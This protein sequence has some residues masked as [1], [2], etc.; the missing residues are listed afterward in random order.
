MIQQAE[1]ARIR[2]AHLLREVVEVV[3][4]VAVIFFAIRLS[5]ATY[6]VNGPSM[7]PNFLDSQLMAINRLSYV[8]G[9]PQRGDV[10]VVD[11]HPLDPRTLPGDGCVKRIIGIP[12]DTVIVTPTS[13]SVDGHQLNEPYILRDST[14]QESSVANEWKLGANQ[15][16]VMGDNRPISYDS[17]YWGPV[18]RDLI[19]GKVFLV[20]WP[21]GQIHGV[22]TYPQTFQGV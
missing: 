15:Y 3:L 10:V 2:R 20:F 1:E 12:G 9:S 5:L 8:F 4:L 22:N 21:L 11:C 13:V 19:V 16:F 7:I 14:G 6:R 18:N 17:R